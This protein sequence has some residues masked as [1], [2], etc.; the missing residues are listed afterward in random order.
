MDANE[1]WYTVKQF[2]MS[3]GQNPFTGEPDR[4]SEDTVRRR[5]ADG[6]LK[7]LRLP[8]RTNRRKRIYKTLLIS[9]SER[10][11]FI[12]ANMTS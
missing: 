12:R 10:E 6:L 8:S 5:I 2:A 4:I 3:F 7:A 9:E 1:K 11:R